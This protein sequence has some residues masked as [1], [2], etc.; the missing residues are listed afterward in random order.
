MGSFGLPN[1]FRVTVGMREENER[2]L[3]GLR[4]LLAEELVG[5]V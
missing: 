3:F 2:F 1:A 4:T 5:Q